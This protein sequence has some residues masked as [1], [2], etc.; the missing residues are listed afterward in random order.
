M[1]FE[2]LPSR[3]RTGTIT[4]VVLALLLC[5]MPAT[6]ATTATA[7][8]M[9][10]QAGATVVVEEGETVDDLEAFAGTVI[11][12]GTVTGDVNAVAGD[13]RIDGE[14]GGDVEAAG[15]SVTIGGDVDGNVEA[16]TGSL[17]ILDGATVGGTLSAGAGT[18]VIDGTV[19]NN[20][21]IGAE[22]IQLGEAA[23]LEGDLRYGGSLEG[24]TDA[25]AGEIE[26]DSTLAVGEEIA[27]TIQPLASWLFSLYAL[28]LNLLLGAALLALFPRFSA[29]VADRVASDP[30]RTGLLGVGV[31]IGVPIL[32]IAT[33]ITVIG[34]PLAVIGLFAFL[35]VLWVGIV[36]GRFAVAAWL[37]SVGG[38]ENRW[39]ALV[40][41][42][43]GGALLAQ[44]P[45]I[46]GLFNLLIFLLGLGALA[47]GL[48]GHRRTVRERRRRAGLDD[49]DH[50][51]DH[52]GDGGG[53]RGP[54]PES[55]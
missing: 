31:L 41:G 24:N 17:E 22:T 28:V 23:T 19:S 6:A 35:L 45:W 36:Y 49:H 2:Q 43:V 53:E 44:V 33:M 52:E 20:V 46:G 13:V 8:Q 39:L 11:V 29:G 25:V 48:Y 47:W 32:L 40:V 30:V 50:D 51:Y 5:V 4:V 54:G 21:A 15:G 12:E 7:A 9:G 26:R 10:P 18:V 34:I 14:V 1:S 55:G 27:P 37:L 16:A 42:L 38:V 3:S